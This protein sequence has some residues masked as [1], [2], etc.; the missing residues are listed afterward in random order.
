MNKIFE[1]SILTEEDLYKYL[2]KLYFNLKDGDLEACVKRAYLDICRT[3]HRIRKH[4]GKEELFANAKKKVI[5]ILSRIKKS[6]FKNQKEFD[7]YH[8]KASKE[9]WDLY[10]NNGFKGF[11]IGH[12][13]K[14]I[15]MTLKYIFTMKE[16]R[17][18]GYKHI[19]QYSHVPIDNIIK[20]K[21]K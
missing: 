12:S 4:Q 19:Y 2:I 11:Y 3:L 20:K 14:W 17:I 8:E 18:P 16:K 1:G 15:N 6:K 10:H 9:L 21:L 5:E 7:E 13:Q